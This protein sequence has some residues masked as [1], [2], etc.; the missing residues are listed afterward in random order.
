ATI[1]APARAVTIDMVTVGN[2]GNS[3]DNTT[4]YGAVA[5]EYQIG[6]YDVT[7]QQYTDFLNAVALSDPY[8]LYNTSMASDLNI[9]GISRCVWAAAG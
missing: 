5:Y 1:T 3:N 4:G 6:K 2:A 7:I 9:A 8:S